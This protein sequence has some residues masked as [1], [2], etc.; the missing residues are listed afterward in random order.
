LLPETPDLRTRTVKTHVKHVLAKLG[1]V[2]RS[3]A[4][5]AY[6]GVAQD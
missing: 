1:V 5:A 4:I 2:N 3:Q 6:L